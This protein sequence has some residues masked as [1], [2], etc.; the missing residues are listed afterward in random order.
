MVRL[1]T[2]G[3]NGV[4]RTVCDDSW[5]TADANVVCRQLG[6]TGAGHQALSNAAFGEG[7]GYIFM[8]NVAC[9]GEESSLH[10]CQFKGW[11]VH[12]CGHYEDAGVICTI[13][14]SC[15]GSITNLGKYG[16]VIMLC[17]RD[18]TAHS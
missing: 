6:Y 8:D 17:T 13:G 3:F 7:N 1:L 4:W 12:N 16:E 2:N 15:K 5:G 11:G 14:K 10:D 9:F 18:V